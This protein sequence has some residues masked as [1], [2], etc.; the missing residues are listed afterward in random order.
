MLKLANRPAAAYVGWTM[1]DSTAY[2]VVF[3]AKGQ[4]ACERIDVPAPTD[5]QVSVRAVCSLISTGT[6]TT[7][8]NGNFAPGTH[9]HEWAQY[10]FYPGYSMIGRVEAVGR[11][12]TRVKPGDLVAARM[13]HQSRF[14]AG[15]EEVFPVPAGVDPAEAA[16]FALAKITYIGAQAARYRLGGSAIIVGCG[17]IGQ[18]SVRW[19][20][21]SGQRQ[22][23]AVDTAADRV[24]Y[25]AAHGSQVV[26]IV[27]TALASREAILERAGGVMPETIVDTTGHPR[28]FADVL[29]LS[30]ERGRVVLLGDAGNPDDQHLTGDLITKGLTITGAHDRHI[31]NLKAAPVFAQFFQ[32][33]Q[34]R[35]MNLAPLNTHRFPASECRAAYELL[36]TQREKTLGVI[37][38]WA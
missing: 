16:W 28:V 32:L 7:V 5:Q 9:W 17:P 22:V 38:D 37:F 36:N 31:D 29:R 33:L 13:K 19:A 12:V 21:V 3:T 1:P 20:A 6:E 30:G 14:V 26:P 25:A 18:L 34:S 27:G 8:L 23:F 11:G 35:Q 2:A 15:E 4:V 24:Q 10:P